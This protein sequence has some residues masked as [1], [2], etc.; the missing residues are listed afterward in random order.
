MHQI[1]LLLKTLAF[2]SHSLSN[3]VCAQNKHSKT[4]F[5]L[6]SLFKCKAMFGLHT[7]FISHFSL[8]WSSFHFHLSFNSLFH[9]GLFLCLTLRSSFYKIPNLP[10]LHLSLF[11]GSINFLFYHITFNHMLTYSVHNS[12]FIS[13]LGKTQVWLNSYPEYIIKLL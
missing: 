13:F 5:G 9:L 2:S 7:N 4:T 3:M 10:F 1:S 11:P 8:F 12:Q 6:I